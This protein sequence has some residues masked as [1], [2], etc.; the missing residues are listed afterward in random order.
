MT[1]IFILMGP[2]IFDSADFP[3]T[4]LEKSENNSKLV[5]ISFSAFP[6]TLILVCMIDL[7]P[8]APLDQLI[9]L[10]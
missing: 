3:K 10:G 5:I 2:G 7:S 9:P 6:E 8:L 4:P 1:P